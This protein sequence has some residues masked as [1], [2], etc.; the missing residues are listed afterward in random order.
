M[1]CCMLVCILFSGFTLAYNDTSPK[2]DGKCPWSCSNCVSLRHPSLDH[3][4]LHNRPRHEVQRLCNIVIGMHHVYTAYY[5][6]R[7]L[8]NRPAIVI[9]GYVIKQPA[10]LYCMTIYDD[11]STE[12]QSVDQ[13]PLLSNASNNWPMA[14]FCK[15][16]SRQK[17][18][19]HVMLSADSC[20]GKAKWSSPI[21]VLKRES[22][23][24]PE[25]VGV[26]VEVRIHDGFGKVL[27][28]L[29]MVK[30]LGAKV[31]TMYF[32]LILRNG[33]H[34]SNLIQAL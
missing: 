32:I 24:V 7:P 22:T 21:P 20:C 29:A 31:V 8:P 25:G 5:D 12:C 33:K 17:V 15:S 3:A 14:Y 34:L 2:I 4:M 10:H 28:F 6:T 26:C 27:E 16:K 23:A 1:F 13:S 18:P 19:T 9:F 30:T 11:D